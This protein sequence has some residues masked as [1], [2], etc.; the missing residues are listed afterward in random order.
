MTINVPLNLL[1]SFMPILLCGTNRHGAIRRAIENKITSHSQV[2][3]PDASTDT[4]VEPSRSP[5]AFLLHS[6]VVEGTH[7][8]SARAHLSLG[9]D[10]IKF[11]VTK[12][13]TSLEMPTPALGVTLEVE[14]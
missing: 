13:D 1:A 9:V 3:E 14:L 5:L 7:S 8:F 12:S 10:A 4:V 2:L 6:S 11:I